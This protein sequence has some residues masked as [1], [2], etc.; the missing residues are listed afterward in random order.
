MPG[1][2]SADRAMLVL[3]KLIV[4]NMAVFSFLQVRAWNYYY[5]MLED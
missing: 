5:R 3:G 1:S 2:F 4:N